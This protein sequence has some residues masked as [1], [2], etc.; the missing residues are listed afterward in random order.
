MKARHR[1]RKKDNSQLENKLD[2]LYTFSADKGKLRE[3]G[4]RK[5]T[6]LSR[7]A[8]AIFFKGGAF[9]KNKEHA[10]VIW[11]LGCRKIEVVFGLY[12]RFCKYLILNKLKN[13]NKIEF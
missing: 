1:Q 6:D 3:I 10:E 9:K 12:R 8:K 11:W 2:I 5:A 7:L 13:P 4:G